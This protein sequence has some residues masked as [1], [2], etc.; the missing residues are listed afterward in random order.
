MKKRA[1]PAAYTAFLSANS[2]SPIAGMIASYSSWSS[3]LITLFSSF[4]KT[5]VFSFSGPLNDARHS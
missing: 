3:K 5:F 2:V 4:V 1:N